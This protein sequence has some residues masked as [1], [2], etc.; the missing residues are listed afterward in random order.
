LTRPVKN[1][2]GLAATGD[3][4]HFGT[5]DID[6]INNLFTG[7]D[8]SST[9]AID[10]NTTWKYRTQKLALRDPTNT[11]STTIAGAAVTASSTYQ[12]GMMFPDYLV[13]VSGGTY[14]ALSALGQTTSNSS[15]S[16]LING[17]NTT[18]SAGG[19]IF[20]KGGAYVADAAITLSNSIDLIGA[21][22][23]KTTIQRTVAT[24]DDTIL[25][26]GN[27]NTIARLTFDGN[28]SAN[29]TCTGAELGLNGIHNLAYDIEVKN[30]TA[31]G[32]DILSS[33][34]RVYDCVITGTGIDVIVP[35]TGAPSSNI[36]IYNGFNVSP[37]P[38]STVISRCNFQ[39][40][41]QNAV[42]NENIATIEGCF[43]YNNPYEAG[44]QIIGSSIALLTQVI[45]CDIEATHTTSIGS[46]IEMDGGDWIITGNRIANQGQWGIV[47]NADGVSLLNSL[48][49]AN[50][51]IKNCHA[52]AIQIQNTQPNFAI[53][54]NQLF[55]DKATHTQTY[56][57]VI[58]AHASNHYTIANNICFN[59]TT[60][61]ISDLGT[62]T[63][64]RI[65]GNI[66][67]NPV[68][69]ITNPFVASGAG[70]IGNAS[71]AGGVAAPA[72]GTVQT[73][74]TTPK[75][76]IQTG[77]TTV[78]NTSINGTTVATTAGNYWFKLGGGE[79][80]SVTYSGA[81]T[82]TVYCE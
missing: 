73:V 61:A 65:I 27:N 29:K 76:I 62:G 75:T 52:P 39:Q 44:G 58:A 36:G 24:A 22:R 13:Y 10:M 60:A 32:I 25:V 34:G 8:Q 48:L 78:S 59:N 66:G 31:H 49:I 37:Q 63:D 69:V 2:T 38:A 12:F 67:Y 64:K 23:G 55:D 45:N 82:I 70:N 80:Y 21:G 47:T 71:P 28:Y 5:N 50:N 18:L 33:D 51:V 79:T 3:S 15:F 6:Q 35:A 81:P 41:T 11:Y 40:V 68:G 53:I 16:S 7:Q 54:H 26:T 57:V 77:G 46:A 42:F 14:Y 4:T 9:D 72:S 17:L 74:I 43:F 30:F 1:L 20:L 19:L 56:G